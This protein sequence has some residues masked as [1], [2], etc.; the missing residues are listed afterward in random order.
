MNY[1]ITKNVSVWDV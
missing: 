1:F